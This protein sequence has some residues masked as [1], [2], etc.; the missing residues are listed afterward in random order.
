MDDIHFFGGWPLSLTSLISWLVALVLALI[1]L[2]GKYIQDRR[3]AERKARLE[4]TNSQ[5]RELYGPL[6]ALERAGTA[7]YAEFRKRYRPNKP[8]FSADKPPTAADLS[9]WRLWMTEVFMPVNLQMENIILANSHLILGG[10]FPKC[11]HELLAHIAAYKPVLKRWKDGDFGDHLSVIEFPHGELPAYLSAAVILLQQ[12]QQEL[13]G[14]R[15][16]D[17]AASSVLQQASP[18]LTLKTH[19]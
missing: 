5:L 11:F 9:A 7:T 2:A 16:L 12:H 1:G 17:A 13:L 14:T 15:D 6:F 4:R 19:S 18:S 8:Y 10:Y 3:I